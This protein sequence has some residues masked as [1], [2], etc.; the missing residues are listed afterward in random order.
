MMWLETDEAAVQLV[1]IHAAKGLSTPLFSAP[2]LG[3]AKEE[4]TVSQRF[5]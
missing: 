2:F 4:I 1:T 5:D 3:I